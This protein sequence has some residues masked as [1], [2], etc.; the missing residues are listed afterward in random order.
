MTI[1]NTKVVNN[2]SKYIVRSKGIGS[3]IDQ[4]VVDAEKLIDGNNKSLVS[5]IECFYIIKGSGTITLSA[6]SE[7]NDLTLTGKGKYGLRPD[8]LKFGNDKQILLT[9]DSNV[10]SY[11]LVTEFRR[12]N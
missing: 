6:S 2:T 1:A 11:L 5:L 12:N 9:T 7:E 3:E 8:Q 10:E 4:I